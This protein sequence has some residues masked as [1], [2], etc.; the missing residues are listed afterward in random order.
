L[1]KTRLAPEIETNL[2]RISQEAL[3]NVWKHARAKSA[4]LILDKRGSLIILIVEDDGTG[5]DV[6]DKA[7]RSEGLGLIGMRERAML[8]GGKIQIESTLEKGTTVFVRIPLEI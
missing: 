1:D 6:E 8:V 4:N 3:N 5:F 7:K 2:Y